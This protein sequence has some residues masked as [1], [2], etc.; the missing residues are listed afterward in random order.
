[1]E[2]LRRKGRAQLL[3]QCPPDKEDYNNV[4][5]ISLN[6]YHINILEDLAPFNNIQSLTMVN[7]NP[8]L[9]DTLFN[10]ESP[11]CS[12]PVFTSGLL[13]VLDLSDNELH[14][15]PAVLFP[16]DKAE[17]SNTKPNCSKLKRLILAGNK[18]EEVESL[19]LASLKQYCPHLQELD[20]C[21]NEVKNTIV[22]NGENEVISQENTVKKEE[23]GNIINFGSDKFAPY[24]RL[25]FT[26][27]PSLLVLD[28]SGRA[29]E[30]LSLSDNSDDDDDSDDS[31]DDTSDDSEIEESE[32]VL[33]R[34]RTDTTGYD[35]DPLLNEKV[36]N[37]PIS[38]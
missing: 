31:D 24:R 36:N 22:K 5:S 37:I 13:T 6:T 9:K 20:L 26:T 35:N 28:G 11:I 27:I 32:P 2:V 12:L 19:K 1:M 3:K 18:I 34:S 23:E 8:C 33:K 7:M 21:G 30:L 14:C 16:N 29:G 15:V 25:I 17:E 10:A 38:K 4:I